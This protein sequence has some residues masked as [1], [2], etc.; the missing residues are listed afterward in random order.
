MEVLEKP[1]I[2]IPAHNEAAVIKSTLVTLLDGL[3]P[4]EVTIIVAANGCTDDTVARARSVAPW[5][6]VLDLEK[7]SKAA[8]IRAAEAQLGPCSRLYLDADILLPGRSALAVFARLT[9]FG[10]GARPPAVT[11]LSGATW[12]VR[13]YHRARKRLSNVQHEFS[14]GGC[15]A[16]S[17]GVRRTFGAFPEVLG[18]DLFAARSIPSGQAEIV[19]TSP[20]TIR[21]PRDASSLR[22]VIVR[23]VRGNQQMAALFPGMGALTTK[24]TAFNLARSVK[25]PASLLDA[26]VYAAFVTS[27]RLGAGRSPVAWERDDSTRQD[28]S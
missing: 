11:D 27:G 24:Q 25:G 21:P 5:I 3:E 15:Y 18:D 23:N 22:R 14:G 12:S 28:H 8:A 13:A 26:V 2:I 10:G 1:A 4:G 20:V 19:D 7:P 6:R 16:L 17:W 9:E